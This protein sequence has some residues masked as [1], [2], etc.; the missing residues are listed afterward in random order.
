MSVTTVAAGL[1]QSIFSLD[2]MNRFLIAAAFVALGAASAG[3]ADLVARRYTKAPGIVDPDYNWSGW[4]IGVNT[5]WIGS[6]SH[7]ITTTATDPSGLLLGFA[8]QA[9]AIPTSIGPRP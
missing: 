4:Y 8:L 9:G 1:D 5:G 7:N 6:T 3:A 2:P